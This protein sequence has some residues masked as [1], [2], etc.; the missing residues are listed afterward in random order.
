MVFNLYKTF[1]FSIVKNKTNKEISK[2]NLMSQIQNHPK[3]IEEKKK[4][5]RKKTIAHISFVIMI[6]ILI[7]IILN[8]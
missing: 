1:F 5:K 4:L 8:I 7:K 3:I 2:N 6:I